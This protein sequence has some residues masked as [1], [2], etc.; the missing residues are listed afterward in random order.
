MREDI[1]CAYGS[2]GI[3][4]DRYHDEEAW[5]QIGMMRAS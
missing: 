3:R 5:Q 4:D 2:R 1:S